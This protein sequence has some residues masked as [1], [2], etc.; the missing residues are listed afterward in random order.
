MIV[1]SEEWLKFRRSK[2]GASDAP[3]IMEESPWTTPMQLYEQKV[4]GFEIPDN[5]Y[6]Q[7]GREL[8]PIALKSFEDSF[9]YIMFPM[10]I[11]H[12]SIEYMVASIDGMTLDKKHAV[13][14]KC[15][16]KRDHFMA[17]NGIVPSKYKAQLQHQMEVCQLDSINYYSF[18]GEEGV[19]I[20]VNRDQDYINILLDRE[21]WFWYCLKNLKTPR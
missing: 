3:I 21:E 18:D 5:P 11:M 10:V 17:L 6:M 15:A 19:N 1:G 7:R 13:E 9:G 16:G 8:E 2:I 14:I 12:K 20:I 4:Y